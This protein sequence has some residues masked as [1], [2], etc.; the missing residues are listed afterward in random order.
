MLFF[1]SSFKHT[2]NF[3]LCHKTRQHKSKWVSSNP[4]HLWFSIGFS[5]GLLPQCF[6]I[7]HLCLLGT[8]YSSLYFLFREEKEYERAASE[9]V[10]FASRNDFVA[11]KQID[12]VCIKLK[13]LFHFARV[14][15]SLSLVLRFYCVNTLSICAMMLLL[16]LCV[17]LIRAQRPVN[18][19]CSDGEKYK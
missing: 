10:E 8:W 11:C 4:A 12:S 1:F 2:P 19:R 13:Y 6:F 15:L 18:N 5:L 17:M 9:W 3:A 14:F 7:T 16:L